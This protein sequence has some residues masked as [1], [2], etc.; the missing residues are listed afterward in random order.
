MCLL[1]RKN[2][3]SN[4]KLNRKAVKLVH[5]IKQQ[6]NPSKI[7]LFGS[8]SRGVSHELSDLDLIIVGQF[9]VPFF[10]RI[11]LILNLNDT[12]LEVDPMVYTEAEFTQMLNED[13]FFIINAIKE[14]IEI[15]G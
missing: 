1:C 13:N 15:Q 6:F 14:G 11:G 3:I 4:K 9:N 10:K 8:L 7:I 2:I 5:K 12:D